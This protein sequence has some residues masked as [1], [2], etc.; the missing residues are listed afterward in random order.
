[1]LHDVR[2]GDFRAKNALLAPDNF[3]CAAK[4]A[5]VP[6]KSATSLT[7][8]AP[9]T[10]AS[11]ATA[12]SLFAARRRSRLGAQ[13]RVHCNKLEAG[14]PPAR[15]PKFE[16]GQHVAAIGSQSAGVAIMQQD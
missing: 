13:E 1:D 9:L 8:R 12:R 7:R 11:G 2:G 14:V 5:F 16:S 3:F 15:Q 4:L 6:A 10:E